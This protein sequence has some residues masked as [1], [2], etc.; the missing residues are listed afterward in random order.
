MWERVCVCVCVVVV[1]SGGGGRRQVSNRYHF[2]SLTYLS[3]PGISPGW[4][5][6]TSFS[7]PDRR[8]S[9]SLGFSLVWESRNLALPPT[10]K[11]LHFSAF[12]FFNYKCRVRP[13]LALNLMI[14]SLL[15]SESLPNSWHCHKES[16][17][18][19]P[20]HYTNRPNPQLMN[21]SHQKLVLSSQVDRARS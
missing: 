12:H 7:F 2:L 3:S 16:E 10:S 11:L 15:L 21:H 13:V 17:S 6:P 14:L 18:V 9:H 19:L 5:I 4:I 20:T 8:D 1:C